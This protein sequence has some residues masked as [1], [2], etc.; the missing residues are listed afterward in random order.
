[1][2]LHSIE[3]GL[4]RPQCRS[5]VRFDHS[6]YLLSSHFPRNLVLRGKRN[7]GRSPQLVSIGK[8]RLIRARSPVNNLGDNSAPLAMNRFREPPQAFYMIVAA[9]A[10]HVRYRTTVGHHVLETCYDQ[11]DA[12]S[13]KFSVEF[14]RPIRNISLIVTKAAP[15]GR[16]YS[17]ISQLQRIYPGVFKK[18]WHRTTSVEFWTVKC[19]EFGAFAVY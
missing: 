3:S 12:A 8:K 13:A 7:G 2:E 1:V 5:R 4:L 16:A 10:D 19:I 9:V 15:G 11:A 6:S 17:P 18:L 14:E